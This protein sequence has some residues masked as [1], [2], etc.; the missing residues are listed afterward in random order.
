MKSLNS[1]RLI[2]LCCGLVA[3]IFI[4]GCGKKDDFSSFKKNVDSFCTEISTIDAAINN[5][6]AESEL[7]VSELLQHLD[8]LDQDFKDFSNLSFPEDYNY[9]EPLADEA[10]EYMS[11][12][13]SSYHTLYQE[14]DSYNQNTASYARENYNR[15]YKRIQIIIAFLHGEDPNELGLSVSEQ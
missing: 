6:D 5:I 3:G 14:E 8:E 9:L 4:T 2:Y 7:A 13:V 10:S 15:A 12:A 1:K 11:E